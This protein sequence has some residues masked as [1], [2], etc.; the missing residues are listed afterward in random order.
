MYAEEVN[1]AGRGKLLKSQNEY[2]LY[3]VAYWVIQM[4]SLALRGRQG[5]IGS[6]MRS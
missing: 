6:E 2:S 3:R 1:D 5:V 4:N